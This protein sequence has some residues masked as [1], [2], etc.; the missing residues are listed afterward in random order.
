MRM[1][2]T[3]VESFEMRFL[4]NDISLPVLTPQTT[5]FGFIN[6]IENS[7]YKITN[8]ILLIFKLHICKSREIGTLELNRLISDIKKLKLL[9]K[10]SCKE[11][12]TI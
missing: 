3:T 8:H 10:G 4:T 12:G 5:I 6:G 7:V 9:E 11:T 1:C 2:Q